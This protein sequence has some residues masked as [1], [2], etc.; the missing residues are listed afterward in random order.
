MFCICKSAGPS[1]KIFTHQAVY[2]DRVVKRFN[3]E[4]ATSS[5]IVENEENNFP[6]PFQG[7]SMITS[8]L[9]IVIWPYIMYGKCLSKYLTNNNIKDWN[10]FK[11]IISIYLVLAI[12]KFVI[13]IMKIHQALMDTKICR[14]YWH[15]TLDNRLHI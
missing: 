9:T 3:L 12:M 10:V 7:S 6:F 2:V 13:K 15:K 1:G 4:D 11:K 5:N 14:W 8:V